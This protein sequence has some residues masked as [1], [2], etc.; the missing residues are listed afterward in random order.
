MKVVDATISVNSQVFTTAT[1][2]AETVPF[3]A[4]GVKG[5]PDNIA[6]DTVI[7]AYGPD[8]K[9][10]PETTGSSTN[11]AIAAPA[12]IP[13]IAKETAVQNAPNSSQESKLVSVLPTTVEIGENIQDVPVTKTDKPPPFVQ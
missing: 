4:E 3:S 13:A 11:N 7:V 9:Q 2:E 8:L 10:L 6:I 5:S 1:T 12:V